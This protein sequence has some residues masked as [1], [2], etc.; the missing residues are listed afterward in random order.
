MRRTIRLTENDLHRVVKESVRQC[1]A[2]LNWKTYAN[3]A[4]KASY[5]GEPE[6]A[7]AFR[8]AAIQNFNDEF[9]YDDEGASL[10]LGSLYDSDMEHWR[11]HDSRTDLPLSMID[12]NTPH[13]SLHYDYANDDGTH[14]ISAVTSSD[15]G[16]DGTRTIHGEYDAYDP[17]RNGFGMS[18]APMSH[19]PLGNFEFSPDGRGGEFKND[20]G[21][22]EFD[23]YRKG[24]YDYDKEKGWHLK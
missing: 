14:R 12:R 4:K 15:I 19:F 5:R 3:A 20:R 6:R 16:N 9:G 21:F 22:N 11:A 17:S 13:M 24:N 18:T 8:D 1:L 7:S 23:N 10:R 2:E